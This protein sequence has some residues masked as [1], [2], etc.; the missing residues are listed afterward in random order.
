MKEKNLE[1][2]QRKEKDCLQR[3]N[4]YM[5]ADFSIER[6][7]AKIKLNDALSYSNKLISDIEFYI[8]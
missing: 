7:E 5:E 2:N 4:F 1:S 6:T 8:Q 3:S